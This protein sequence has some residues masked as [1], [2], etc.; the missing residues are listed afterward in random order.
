[1]LSEYFL[2]GFELIIKIVSPEN[3]F[4][5]KLTFLISYNFKNS[6]VWFQVSFYSLYNLKISTLFWIDLHLIIKL[7]HSFRTDVQSGRRERR[8][9][10]CL[11]R[12]VIDSSCKCVREKMR[13]E[14]FPA[15][16]FFLT[17]WLGGENL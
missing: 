5:L 13:R 16:F 15:T 11:E 6:K 9:R 17:H 7:F 4:N 1:M 10:M 8:Q 14:S 2:S 3:I 12:Q